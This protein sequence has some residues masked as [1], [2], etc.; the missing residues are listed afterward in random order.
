MRRRR[1]TLSRCLV[2]AAL[3]LTASVDATPP[4]G[5]SLHVVQTASDS[6]FHL[7]ASGCV[8]AGR[9]ALNRLATGFAVRVNGDVQL[10]TALHAVA[11]CTSWEIQ[12][13][14]H[15]FATSV[16]R[17]YRPADLALLEKPAG[18]HIVGL[19]MTNTLPSPG[20]VLEALGYGSTP[21]LNPSH[22]FVRL[23][24]GQTIAQLVRSTE[25]TGAITKQR[26]PDVDAPIINLE[27]HLTPG[28]SGAPIIDDAGVV[29]GVANGNLMQGAWPYSW[30]FPASEIRALMASVE[31]KLPAITLAGSTVLVSEEVTTA[32]DTRPDTKTLT[33]TL[34]C[35][36]RT[37]QFRGTQTFSR[38]IASADPFS[39]SHIQLVQSYAQANGKTIRPDERFDVY[40]DDV[41][42][43]DF[44]L[45]SGFTIAVIGNDCVAKDAAGELEMRISTDSVADFAFTSGPA[46]A[47]A[48]R[49]VHSGEV[50]T[51]NPQF[52]TAPM[53]RKDGMM[54]QRYAFFYGVQ[55]QMPPFNEGYVT[56]AWR[57]GTLLEVS[58]RT[59]VPALAVRESPRVFPS[60]VSV[61]AATFTF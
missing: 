5:P 24:G 48:A 43:A 52:S 51:A 49:M 19:G 27:S 17:V 9:P 8:V 40:V 50:F 56:L 33:A 18:L 58:V 22:V 3:F 61:Y 4:G 59:L 53:P 57:R 60:V 32:L 36:V 14:T 13:Q 11:G 47:F 34:S 29:V 30:A 6:V 26:F 1:I 54:L 46:V 23:G 45:P 28:D 20:Q 15:P 7:L 55:G 2:A 25:V 41:S 39:A 38:L 10:V 35:G 44:L 21:S 31:T 42:G 16:L 12:H 37:F